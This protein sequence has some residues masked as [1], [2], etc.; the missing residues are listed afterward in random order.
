MSYNKDRERIN[1]ERYAAGQENARREDTAALNGATLGILVAL[2]IACAAGAFFFLSNRN[3][4]A[5]TAPALSPSTAPST[6]APEKQTIIR[7]EK[8]R[9]LVPVPQATTQPNIN[10]TVPSAPAPSAS[11]APPSTAASS[12]PSTAPSSSVQTPAPQSPSSPV[13]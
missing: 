11:S 10:I 13:N 9:E 1:T 2:A 6:A 3:E 4:T 8:T 7:E 12:S 5:P